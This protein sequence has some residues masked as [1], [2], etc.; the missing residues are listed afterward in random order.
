M[1]HKAVGRTRKTFIADLFT[2]VSVVEKG[3]EN[4]GFTTIIKSRK[5]AI[6]KWKAKGLRN[7]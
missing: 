1:S 5:C 2:N 7:E 4:A 3:D 6:L